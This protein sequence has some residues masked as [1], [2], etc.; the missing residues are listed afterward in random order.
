VASG[1]CAETPRKVRN[2]IG[3]FKQMFLP[4]LNQKVGA[5]LDKLSTG[6]QSRASSKH[7]KSQWGFQACDAL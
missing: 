3:V 6:A 4:E 1:H 5:G 7:R 2:Y